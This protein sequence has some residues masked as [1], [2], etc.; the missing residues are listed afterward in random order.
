MAIEINGVHFREIGGR[1]H[2][3]RTD[4]QNDLDWHHVLTLPIHE[5]NVLKSEFPSV[6]DHYHLTNTQGLTPPHGQAYQFL[7]PEC[8]QAA[9]AAE[10]GDVRDFPPPVIG[11]WASTFRVQAVAV[12]IVPPK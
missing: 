10:Q 12:A 9:G 7:R 6:A 3:S 5:Y 1:L 8:W 11:Q 4:S 2:A